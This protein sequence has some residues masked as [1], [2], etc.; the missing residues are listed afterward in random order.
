VAHKLNA[1][2]LVILSNVPGLLRNVNDPASLVHS[3]GLHEMDR[4]ESLALGRMKKKLL[5]ATQAGVA[6][7]ILAGV[8]GETPLD[9]ALMGGGTHVIGEV[10]H[11]EYQ[12]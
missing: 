4:Y 11:V 7:V 2:A 12:S 8:G 10:L 1:A 3:F 5:A 6:R 9:A